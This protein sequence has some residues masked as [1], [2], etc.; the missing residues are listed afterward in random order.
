MSALRRRASRPDTEPPVARDSGVRAALKQEDIDT[1]PPPPP[2]TLEDVHARATVNQ[3][4]SPEFLAYLR[5]FDPVAVP[6]PAPEPAPAPAPTPADDG[7][8]I[9]VGESSDDPSALL[10]EATAPPLTFDAE[11]DADELPDFR[12]RKA[13][14]AL[15]VAG[16]VAAGIA[17]AALFD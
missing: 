2:A 15:V 4:L 9:E 6:G 7:P 13:A 14:V 5:S 8:V 16:I 10:D 17:L 1:V 3:K 12:D 11:I